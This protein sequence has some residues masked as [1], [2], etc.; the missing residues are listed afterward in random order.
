MSVPVSLKDAERKAF[1]ATF[2]DGVWDIVLGLQ[3]LAWGVAPLLEET[4]PLSDF[5]VAILSLPIMLVLWAGKKFVTT[6]RMGLVKFGPKRKAGLRAMVVI[7]CVLLLV[8]A[9]LGFL[10]A[11]NRVR[12]ELTTG[13]SIPLV[14]WA[15]PLIMCFSAAAY[16][17]DVNRL[18]VYGVL[19]AISMP[20]RIIFKQSPDLRGISLMGFFV[21]GG[22]ILLT[23]VVLAIR[24][25]RDYPIPKVAQLE[26]PRDGNR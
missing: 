13:L 12:P 16:F 5:W 23:G 25:L 14:A 2:Q 26:G 24:F 17:T 20:I 18:Y 15:L 19:F 10:I 7:V 9:L 1:T 8:A 6:P 11:T 21:A 4:L 3:L 22:I